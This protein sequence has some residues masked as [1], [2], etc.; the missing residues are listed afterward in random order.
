MAEVDASVTPLMPAAQLYTAG[1][2]YSF[3]T[4]R[5]PLNRVTGV[6]LTGEKT[7][8]LSEKHTETEIWKN[9]LEDDRL[10]RVVTGMYSAQMLD[11]VKDRSFGRCP[12]CPRTSAGS[13]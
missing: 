1:M 10:Y 12:S 7:T 8:V 3:N 5:L 9:D 2:S 6:W 11:T 4:H 13:Q